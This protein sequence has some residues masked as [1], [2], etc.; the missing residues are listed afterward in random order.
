MAV[1]AGTRGE[2]R[3]EQILEVSEEFFAERGFEA[4]NL[5][6]VAARLG[7]KRQAIYYYF[8]S[9]DEILVELVARGGSA[10]IDVVN[11]I[12]DSDLPPREKLS[13]VLAHH[14]EHVLG[15]PV[16]FRVQFAEVRRM[17]PAAVARVRQQQERYV[18]NVAAVIES[19][20]LAGQFVTGPTIPMALMML[21]MCNATLDWY[22]PG[23]HM[24]IPDV[25]ALAVATAMDGVSAP[26][27]HA[28]E[29]VA[30]RS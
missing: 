16:T 23:R 1:K 17:A 8:R 14:V 11:P 3:R 5:D 10:L 2:S 21:G 24:A 22:Q 19:G 25:A 7:V 15:N 12:L 20:Q 13:R 18:K 28:V 4:T 26:S 27:E 29:A 30:R 9:K 6:L